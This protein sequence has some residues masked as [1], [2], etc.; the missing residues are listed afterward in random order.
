MGQIE[1][2]FIKHAFSWV[3]GLGA[4]GALALGFFLG[5]KYGKYA[6]TLKAAIKGLA[7]L[8]GQK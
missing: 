5:M 6:E 3:D 2:E 7:K 4:S 1:A 8:G